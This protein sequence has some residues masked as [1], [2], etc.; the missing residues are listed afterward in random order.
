M[1]YMWFRVNIVINLMM[2]K[3]RACYNKLIE[4]SR[5][6]PNPSKCLLEND[7]ITW[8]V[9]LGM[10]GYVKGKLVK[11]NY[12]IYNLNGHLSDYLLANLSMLL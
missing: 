5:V 9:D 11:I 4:T 1:L 12:K 10:K 7:D 2:R 6:W 3:K 8:K